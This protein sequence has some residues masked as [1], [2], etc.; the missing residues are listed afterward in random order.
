MLLIFSTA[1]NIARPE[2]DVP[3]GGSDAKISV[4]MMMVNM[5]ICGPLAYQRMPEANS[6]NQLMTLAV[7]KVAAR[8]NPRQK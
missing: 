3:Q 5:M 2:H 8:R 7:H 4:G 1:R 6:V